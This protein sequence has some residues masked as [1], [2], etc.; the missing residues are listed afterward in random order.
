MEY[1]PFPPA[2]ANQWLMPKP[3]A[4]LRRWSVP[5]LWQLTRR[6]PLYLRFREIAAAPDITLEGRVGPSQQTQL[7]R[8][9]LSAI[10]ITHA[11]PPPDTPADEL[12]L[13]QLG[14]AW[15]ESAVAPLTL[16]GLV[17]MLLL[18]LPPETCREVGTTLFHRSTLAAD[19]HF[20]HYELLAHVGE[21]PW[22]GLDA[23]TS[24]PAVAVNAHIGTALLK[25]AVTAYAADLRAAAGIKDTRRR[26]DKM[27]SYLAVWDRREGWKGT[28]YDFYATRTLAQ[29]AQ[30]RGEPVATV[31]SQYDAAYRAVVGRD[32]VHRD[33]LILFGNPKAAQ[34]VSA[35]GLTPRYRP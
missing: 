8:I 2:L 20:G 31:R 28:G 6:H 19:D 25:S 18:D 1:E 16:R 10:G 9:M 17:T 5:E 3:V 22:P 30:E 7:T 23:V 33:W 21:A 35:A 11:Y 29:V 26:H 4:E 34:A 15:E 32:Y 24:R 27:E 12:G 14:T 13:A